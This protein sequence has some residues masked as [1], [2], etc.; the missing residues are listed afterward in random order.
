MSSPTNQGVLLLHGLARTK[1]SMQPMAHFLRRQGYLV[2]NQGYASRHATIEQLAEHAVATG[3]SCLADQGAAIVHVVTHSMGGILLR[4]YLN[5]HQPLSLGR[6]VMLS[7]PNQG[8]ELVDVLV[9]FSWFRRVFGPA[10][11]Q[12]STGK[13]ALPRRLGAVD[14]PLGI[15][16]GNRPAIGLGCF[17]PGPNDGKV[18]VQRAQIDGMH[19]LL[20]LACGHSLIMRRKAVQEQVL[21]F[22]C[23][24]SFNRA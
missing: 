20:V 16:T 12:L 3:F 17:F 2:H 5:T 6:V 11:C 13:D 15:I 4:S 18:S 21:Q 24:G 1:R 10:G 9:R 23:T 8:S 7:P 19:D 14:F 22:L